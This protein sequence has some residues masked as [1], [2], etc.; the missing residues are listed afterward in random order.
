MT[1]ICVEQATSLRIYFS[2]RSSVPVVWLYQW[3]L[4]RGTTTGFAM[5][6]NFCGRRMQK[7][8]AHHADE[9]RMRAC[10]SR[11]DHLY[12]KLVTQRSRLCIQVVKHFHVIGNKPDGT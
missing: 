2:V 3:P 9:L 12:S 6:Q 10:R 5:R 11:A 4:R 8:V 1:V 7:H